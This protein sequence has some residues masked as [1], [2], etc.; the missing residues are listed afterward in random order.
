MNIEGLRGNTPLH[1]AARDG[2]CLVKYTKVKKSKTIFWYWFIHY[3]GNEKV[4]EI[5]VNQA[6]TDF[7]IQNKDNSTPLH[8][9]AKLGSFLVWCIQIWNPKTIL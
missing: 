9:A 7:N 3:L 1:I 5:L 2:N 4:V 6:Q 8:L